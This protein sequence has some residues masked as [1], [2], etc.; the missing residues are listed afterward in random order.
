MLLLCVVGCWSPPQLMN[1]EPQVFD[2]A[3]ELAAYDHASLQIETPPEDPSHN[4]DLLATQAPIDITK[5]TPEDFREM[6]L[7]EAVQLA[8][9]NT[10]ILRDLGGLVLRSPSS[11]STVHDPAIQESDPRFGVEAALSAYDASFAASTF[12]EKNDRQL[13]NTFFGGGTRNLKQ[14]AGVYQTQLS[15]TGATGTQYILRNNV[16]YDANNAPGNLFSS[17]WNMNIEAEFRHPL[18]QGAGLQFNRIAGPGSSEGLANGVLI[19]RLNSDVSLADFEIGVTQFVSDVE[20]AYW[21]LYFAYRDLDAKIKARDSALETWRRIQ[22]KSETG[23]RGGEEDKEAQAREQYFRLEE[24]VQNALNG[25]LIEG[26][27]SNNGSSGGTFR[28]TGGVYVAE[29]RLRLMMGLVINDDRIIR[30]TTEPG[31]ANVEFDWEFTLAESLAR[32]PELRRQKWLVKRRELELEAAKNFLKPQLDAVGRWRWRGFGRDLIRQ[33]GDQPIPSNGAIP[34]K[35]LANNAFETL[36]DGKFQEWQVG[37]E[38]SIPLGYR[39]AHANV[40]NAELRLAKERTVLREQERE[41]VHNLSNAVAEK[42][43]AYKAMQ[44]SFNRR[45]AAKTQYEALLGLFND[46]R[47]EN[48]ELL[49]SAQ[50]RLAEAEASYF[51]AMV[52]FSL[53]VKN[54]HFE[55]GSLLDFNEVYLAEGE[56]PLP[57]YIQAEERRQ[58]RAD[59]GWLKTLFSNAPV[60]TEGMYPQLIEAVPRDASDGLPTVPPPSEEAPGKASLQFEDIQTAPAP[61]PLSEFGSDPGTDLPAARVIQPMSFTTPIPERS[62]PMGSAIKGRVI[63]ENTGTIRPLPM[64]AGNGPIEDLNLDGLDLELRQ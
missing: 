4:S 8:L 28:G 14:D 16:D 32:R 38:L 58:L 48:Q 23:R 22:T 45:L 47:L 21:D 51:K 29:R 13:N 6:P 31:M 56:S 61:T 27:R 49:L 62:V 26:T 5:A 24:E 37:F 17:V 57:A 19:A 20:N 52:E 18:M 2:D 7:N 30:P 39:R 59:L 10:R 42:R 63:F 50:R 53:S 35:N 40:R 9:S 60:V 41:I 33:N 55:K 1:P 34:P 43:R 54:V 46:D 12:V 11:T 15:K 3:D 64:D 44:I 25:R 36:N